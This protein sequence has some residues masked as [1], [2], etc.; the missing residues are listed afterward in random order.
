M[1][2]SSQ[3]I[4]LVPLAYLGVALSRSREHD[5]EA[6]EIL[7]KV[8]SDA[9]R[10]AVPY[11][12]HFLWSRAELSRLLRR[13]DRTGEA[14]KHEDMLRCVNRYPPMTARHRIQLRFARSW[15]LDRSTTVSLK[16]FNALVSDDTDSGINHILVHEDMR[17]LFNIEERNMN[18]LLSQF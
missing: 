17:E 2:P 1:N 7:T 14:E 3:T 8:L 6:L 9:H 15:I 18:Q 12:K 13:L 5:G 11:Q 16:E 4:A 10:T